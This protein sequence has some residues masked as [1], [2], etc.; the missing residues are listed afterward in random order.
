MYRPSRVFLSFGF[1]LALL[2]GTFAFHASSP[3]IAQDTSSD[4]LVG[5]PVVGAWALL[6]E[7]EVSV[8]A[9]TSDGIVMDSEQDGASG[10][11]SWESS[12]DSSAAFTFIILATEEENALSIAIR[13]TMEVDASGDTAT[14]DYSFTV[15]AA[16]GTVYF[17]DSGSA[18]A[19]R[20]PVEG[21]ELVGSPVA[22]FPV[23][24][25][26]PGA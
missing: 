24:S 5:H 16:D 18:P 25:G 7:G 11:G 19:S 1:V 3:A 12:G 22:G 4:S 8:I 2:I 26:T 9:F 6:A 23:V 10:V 14:V 17:A 13:G 20:I 21:P 15:V